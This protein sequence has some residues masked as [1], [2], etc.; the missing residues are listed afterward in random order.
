[1]TEQFIMQYIPERM[2]Q[3]GYSKW[4]IRYRDFFLSSVSAMTM[5]TYNE[6]FYIVGSPPEVSVYSDY[7]EYRALFTTENRYEHKG[8]I[9]ISNEGLQPVRVKMIQVIIVN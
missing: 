3:L 5:I 9:T 1:M 6:L 7:G 2:K 4:H 8:E